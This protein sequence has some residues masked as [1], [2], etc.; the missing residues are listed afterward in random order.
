MG[1]VL[2]HCT[3]L[4][5]ASCV[6]SHG[7]ELI[8]AFSPTNCPLQYTVPLATS[9]VKPS[10]ASPIGKYTNGKYSMGSDMATSNHTNYKSSRTLSLLAESGWAIQP[11]RY[12]EGKESQ[13]WWREPATAHVRFS[14]GLLE[15]LLKLHKEQKSSFPKLIY[16]NC[17]RNKL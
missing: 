15:S 9:Q 13:V 14:Q 3:D 16:T 5:P 10:W 12:L 8:D 6:V 11:P 2:L 7:L 1:V 4:K 17:W